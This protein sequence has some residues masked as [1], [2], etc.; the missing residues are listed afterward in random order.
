M[1][2]ISAMM[3][4]VRRCK[5]YADL[6]I[7]IK[8]IQENLTQPLI[9][10]AVTS[11]CTTLPFPRDEIERRLSFWVLSCYLCDCR[12]YSPFAYHLSPINYFGNNQYNLSP[13]ASKISYE[14]LDQQI[15]G[16]GYVIEYLLVSLYPESIEMELSEK[17]HACMTFEDLDRVL[18][19]PTSNFAKQ[20][21]AHGRWWYKTPFIVTAPLEYSVHEKMLSSWVQPQILIEKDQKQ[22]EIGELLLW[23]SVSLLDVSKSSHNGH[24][25]F[26]SLLKGEIEYLIE[27]GVEETIEI[28]KFIHPLGNGYHRYSYAMLLDAY[29]FSF[30]SPGWIVFYNCVADNPGDTACEVASYH[31]VIET[32]Q[33]YAP[34]LN[35]QEMTI[36]DKEFHEIILQWDCDEH[37]RELLKK[38]ER[39][40]SIEQR[41]I[42]GQGLLVELLT[43]YL[44]SLNEKYETIDWNVG[45]AQRN[46]VDVLC[47]ASD[48]VLFLECKKSAY[49]IN[50]EEE[51]QKLWEKMKCYSTTCKRVGQI[52]LY[53]KPT[54]HDLK[55]IRI[56]QKLCTSDDFSFKEV[57]W[58]S[59]KD[60]LLQKLPSL[61]DKKFQSKKLKSIKDAF[62]EEEESNKL[63]WR[64]R[65]ALKEDDGISYVDIPLDEDGEIGVI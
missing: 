14:K 63:P 18:F 10:H 30:S 45:S 29:Q 25:A 9:E 65:I 13:F 48:H 57:M 24:R 62:G 49:S 23:K 31:I 33:E 1:H 5:S 12:H 56:A 11:I 61:Y 55:N 19:T 34:F 53:S 22:R 39:L 40:T 60:G 38:E 43:Y 7:E 16:Y 20:W 46:Q 4:N 21:D 3:Q 42:T 52:I 15:S 36:S 59:G 41:L 54:E 2:I 47:T 64:K 35:I 28:R 6:L 58:L 26:I 51:I 44:Y 37:K 32:L 8:K 50:W 17:I 27:N